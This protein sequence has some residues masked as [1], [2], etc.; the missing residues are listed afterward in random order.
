MAPW[1]WNGSGWTDTEDVPE[2]EAF[3]EAQLKD[4]LF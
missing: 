1:I 2:L 4:E 3:W